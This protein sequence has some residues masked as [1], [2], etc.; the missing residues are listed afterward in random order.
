MTKVT[1]SASPVL[2]S[3]IAKL[4]RRSTG[5]LLEDGTKSFYGQFEITSADLHVVYLTAVAVNSK[6]GERH[7]KNTI[8]FNGSE[9]AYSWSL[10][11]KPAK[12]N[13]KT[14]KVTVQFTL[15]DYTTPLMG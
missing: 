8:V 1:L 5:R 2:P 10:T 4:V 9:N 7:T 14:K 11:Y 6:G 15:D 12:L 3:I 13:H